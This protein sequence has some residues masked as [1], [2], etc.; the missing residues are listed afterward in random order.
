M[1]SPRS[2]ESPPT[3]RSSTAA[4]VRA[5]VAATCKSRSSTS[6]AP[7]VSSK[8]EDKPKFKGGEFVYVPTVIAPITMSYNLPGVDKLQLSPTSI[9]AIFQLEDHEVERSDHRRRQPRRHPA[10]HRHRRRRR[11]DG[12]GTTENFSKFLERVRRRRRRW[13]LEAG[14]SVPELEW[15]DGTQAGDGNSG[16][17]QIVSSTEGAIGYVDLSDAKANNLTFA[18]VKNKAGKYIEPTLEAHDCRCR[19]RQDQRRP[20]LLPRLGRRRRG[21]PDRGADVDHRLHQAGR[22]G[23]G[24]GHSRVPHL[25]ADRCSDTRSVDIDYAPLPAALQAKALDNI[26]K[27]GG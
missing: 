14:W 19:E 10:R 23:Q 2:P 9:A 11:A 27:I 5:R 4:A 8:D 22:R 1:P 15:P 21:V 6:P 3:S 16:V 18:S 26:A 7:T 24:R 20:D 13:H 17:A 25:P 12:S